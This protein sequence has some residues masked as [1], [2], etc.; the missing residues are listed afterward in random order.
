M[1]APSP[2][3]TPSSRP[4]PLLPRYSLFTIVPLPELCHFKV[5]MSHVDIISCQRTKLKLIS[6]S[7]VSPASPPPNPHSLQSTLAKYVILWRKCQTE[8]YIVPENKLGINVSLFCLT[9]P[10]YLKTPL[11]PGSHL[12]SCGFWMFRRKIHINESLSHIADLGLCICIL[13]YIILLA[14]R[15]DIIRQSKIPDENCS[16]LTDRYYSLYDQALSVSWKLETV[17][18][19]TILLCYFGT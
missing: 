12:L 8:T 9:E 2:S 16:I 6:V 10:L 18:W 7:F 4:Q 15:T 11:Y 17:K 5:D 1:C 13:I 19:I 3:P 14:F